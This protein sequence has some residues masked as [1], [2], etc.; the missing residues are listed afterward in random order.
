MSGNKKLILGLV[1]LGIVAC[2][3]LTS[4]S[5][6]A[7]KVNVE[8]QDSVPVRAALAVSQD[9][10]VE[11]SAVGNVEAIESVE[12]KS[13]IAGQI[14]S[15]A[16]AEGQNVA[17]GQL[18]FTIDPDALERQ[19][20]EQRA[21]LERDAAVEQQAQAVVARDK[22]SQKQSQSEAD[23][24]QKLGTLGVISGQR[25]NQLV[26]TS[27]TSTAVLRADE[28]AVKAAIGTTNA[29]RARL[30][31]TQLQLNYAN[32]VA[33][34]AG[35]AGAA[36]VK[37]GNM[38]RESDT[39]LVTLLQLAPIRVSFGVPEQILPEVQ[40][41]NSGGPLTVEAGN[42]E[43]S[44]HEGHLVFID[45]AVDA[46]TGTIRLKAEFPN[47]DGALWPGQFVN[48]RLRLR[49]EPGKTLVPQSAVQ[50]GL[51]GKYVWRV[52]SGMV[53]MAPVTVSRIY[54]PES[55]PAQAIVG[56]GINPGD[57]VVTEGQLRLTP[58]ARVSLLNTPRAQTPQS[59]DPRSSPRSDAP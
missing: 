18:L 49:M 5:R 28:A 2:L 58:G 32:V 41:L 53:A 42:S 38:V 19:A 31:Q 26:T 11:V 44:N 57:T 29:D 45:N 23:I 9:V 34:M 24:A 8:P 33:P 10:P 16:F 6:L 13:R 3:P 4:C 21:E 55:G 39:T 15:V 7:A 30:N 20:A 59:T 1:P 17:K 47:A 12:V 27:D 52:T 25:V 50:D 56:S 46:T 37:A 43:G 36:M 54:R 40:R 51:D 22:A 48:V 35:R 14:K